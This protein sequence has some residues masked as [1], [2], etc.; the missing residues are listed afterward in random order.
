VPG[1]LLGGEGELATVAVGTARLT[2]L[3]DQLLA[4]TS[5]V[6]VSIRAED[7]L[8]VKEGSAIG[9]SARNRLQGV[10]TAIVTEGATVRVELDCGFPLTA[11]LTRQAVAELELVQG[12]GVT[13]LIKAPSVHLIARG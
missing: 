10:V 8:L 11:L 5:G 7:V 1:R 3:G 12:S 9:T 4:G 13:A 2:G 6:L